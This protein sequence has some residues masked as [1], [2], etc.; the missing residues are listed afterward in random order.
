MVL[1]G[2]MTVVTGIFFLLIT[3]VVAP[4]FG[5][6][7]DPHK[8]GLYCIDRLHSWVRECSG[9]KG[10]LL[11]PD[12][13]LKESEKIDDNRYFNNFEKIICAPEDPVP[14]G[15][16]FNMCAFMVDGYPGYPDPTGA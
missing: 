11:I 9:G 2:A 7:E 5:S 1:V 8:D 3:M 10:N 14:D 6:V 13:W 12:Y 15:A 4:V 16:K